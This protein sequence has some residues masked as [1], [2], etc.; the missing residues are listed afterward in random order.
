M[1][2]ADGAH[3][4]ITLHGPRPERLARP[5]RDQAP[6]AAAGKS[7]LADLIA[8]LVKKSAHGPS[9]F[10]FGAHGSVPGGLLGGAGV[11]QPLEL[12]LKLPLRDPAGVARLHEFEELRSARERA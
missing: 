9:P 4:V 7:E 12:A 1:Q 10:E 8:V 2:I 6:M 5:R 11:A 3:A